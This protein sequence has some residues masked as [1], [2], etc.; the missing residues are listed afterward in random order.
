VGV[1][2]VVVVVV[3]MMFALAICLFRTGLQKQEWFDQCEQ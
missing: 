3:E 2:V 1:V